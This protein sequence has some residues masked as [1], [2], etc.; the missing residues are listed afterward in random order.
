MSAIKRALLSN[1]KVLVAGGTAI[2]KDA[3][4]VLRD[5]E[6]FDP[7]TLRFTRTVPMRQTRTQFGMT[8][9][10]DGRVMSVGGDF[11]VIS[12]GKVFPGDSEAF[13]P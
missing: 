2:I 1:G 9:L 13:Q 6:L 3:Y 12:D 5:A 7:A 11:Y 8:T 10:L 4:V